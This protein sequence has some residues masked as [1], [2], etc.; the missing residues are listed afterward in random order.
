MVDF[1]NYSCFNTFLA[2]SVAQNGYYTKYLKLLQPSQFE[3]AFFL[4][5]PCYANAAL[6]IFILFYIPFKNM[7][8]L[9]KFESTGN[10]ELLSQKI[11]TVF[12]SKDTPQEIYPAAEKLFEKLKDNHVSIASGWQ[13]PL[14]KKLLESTYP[15]MVANIIYY[16]AKDLSQISLLPGLKRLDD[17]K[18][19]LVISAQSRQKRATKNDID[20]RDELLFKQVS[21]VIFLYISP[22][23]RLEKYFNRLQEASFPIFVLQ[24]SLNERFLVS[25]CPSI[26]DSNLHE[27]I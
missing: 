23:G 25:G 21:Q 18:K 7:T 13:A 17:K 11:I 12:S 14:E 15:E 10:I 24:H 26:D 8:L 3:K 27:L 4:H 19:L 1:R 6:L 20:K 2:S 5:F 22:D 9:S 16:T